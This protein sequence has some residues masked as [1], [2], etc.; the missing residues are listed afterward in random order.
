[1]AER[2]AFSKSFIL[3]DDFMDLSLEAKALY[4]YLCIVAMDKGVVINAKATAR[5]IQV[6]ENELKTLIDK[7]FLADYEEGHYQI[8]H[9]AENN[10]IGENAKARNSYKYRQ[11]RERIIERDVICQM[12]GSKKNLEVHH[13]KPFAQY[14]ELRYD[15][16]NA[17]VLCKKCHIA[18]HKE[19]RNG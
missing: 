3:G 2:V 15:E 11:F 7:G 6:D 16:D 8:K 17:I 13:T 5:M 18:L 4:F 1:M 9:W 10:G 14:P 12:C 19:L